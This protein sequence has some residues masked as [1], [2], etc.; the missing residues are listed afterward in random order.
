[1][2]SHNDHMKTIAATEFKAHFLQ[3]IDEIARTGKSVLVTKR[4]KPAVV[5]GPPP[6]DEQPKFV[7]GRFDGMAEITGDIVSPLDVEWEAMK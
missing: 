7:I 2:T 4:G 5:V 3:L 1:M 6:H